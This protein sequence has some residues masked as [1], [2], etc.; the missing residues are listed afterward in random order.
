MK[1]I[2]CD[3]CEKEFSKM[4][5]G[6][7]IWKVHGE[8]KNKSSWNKGKSSWNKGLTK[9]IDDR[10]KL[11]GEK[12]SKNILD[13]KTIPS[14]LGTKH[15]EETKKKISIARIKYLKENPD[16]VPYLLNHNSKVSYPEKTMIKYL[17]ELDI[18]GWIHQMSFS[19][20][21]IDFA[22]PE[23]KLAVEIDGATHTL[24][25]VIE[26]DKRK[27]KHLKNNGWRILRITA[28]KVKENVY[29]CINLILNELGEKQL[30]I[31][32]EFFNKK[33]IREEKQRKQKELLLEKSK[34]KQDKKEKLHQERIEII[35]NSNIDIKVVGYY[36]KLGSILNM[37]G[38]GVK[39][40]M[41][42]YML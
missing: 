41:N 2:K 40:F 13:G 9:E 3:L 1:K 8:G 42:K 5:I 22:F 18:K 38:N 31:P 4:G 39:K 35:K 17:N 12:M 19:I 33:F 20:Y 24:P 7:H 14:K 37:T 26:I 21:Q 25:N 6:T 34:E 10:V 23:Y 28:S 36:E 15:T 32:V 11:Y 30:E 16:Q 29:V 27:D